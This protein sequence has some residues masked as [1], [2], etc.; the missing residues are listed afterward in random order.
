MRVGLAVS[1]ALCVTVV[2][3]G[4]TARAQADADDEW[5]VSLTPYAW[6]AGLSGRIGFAGGI[7]N[8]DLSPGDVLSHT[9]I[10]VSALLEARRNRFLLRLNTTYMSMSDR[11]AVEEGSESTVIFE[12]SQTILEPEVGYTVYTAE[13]GAID[14]LAGGRYWHP[15]VDVSADSPGGDL[16]IA[17]GSRSWIDGIGGVRV[18]LNPAERWHMTAKGDA[19]AGGSKLTWQ[20]IGSVGY[21]LS[22]CCSLDAAY[23][24]LDIDYDR[25]ALVN[26]SHLSGFALGIGIRF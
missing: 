3:P 17:S 10:S 6:L 21:D 26:D 19:G 16:P 24:H 9:D 18:R 20:A 2:V 25:D 8:I 5:H 23:R 4:R 7:A 1:I 11:R 22:H 12:H 15:K 13:R 14:V